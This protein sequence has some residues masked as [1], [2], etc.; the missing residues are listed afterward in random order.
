[1]TLIIHLYIPHNIAQKISANNHHGH[2]CIKHYHVGTCNNCS[3]HCQHVKRACKV[4]N[5]PKQS[6]AIR[7][8]RSQS[9]ARANKCE[10]SMLRN[11]LT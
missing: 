7:G 9:K 3:K 4:G 11:G 6:L 2:T 10:Q 5:D 8:K 1:M